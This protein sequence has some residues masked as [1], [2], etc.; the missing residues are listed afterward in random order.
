MPS[1]TERTVQGCMPILRKLNVE[2]A[3]SKEHVS[4][5][6]VSVQAPAPNPRVTLGP[7]LGLVAESGSTAYGSRDPAWPSPH[8]SGPQHGAAPQIL[9]PILL[10]PQVS[11]R[12][13]AQSGWV[14]E[15]EPAANAAQSP[16]A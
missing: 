12:S 3:Q 10:P 4:P 14:L 16:P 6:V 2:E 11:P 5:W 13:W 7:C 1:F 15:L 9:G 8:H